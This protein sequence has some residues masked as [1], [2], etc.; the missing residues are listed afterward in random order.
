MA[1][2]DTMERAMSVNDQERHEKVRRVLRALFAEPGEN[3]MRLRKAF[4]S[5]D[6]REAEMVLTSLNAQEG[7]PARN[8]SVSSDQYRGLKALLT[9]TK[10]QAISPIQSNSPADELGQVQREVLKF[11]T[12]LLSKQPAEVEDL[13]YMVTDYGANRS[14]PFKLERVLAVLRRYAPQ[15]TWERKHAD[16]LAQINLQDIMFKSLAWLH[17]PGAVW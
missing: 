2:T 3:A 12:E 10:F 17:H 6:S 1:M 13:H 7:T 16:A 9:E 5:D 4:L 8:P 15:G 11:W 14:D